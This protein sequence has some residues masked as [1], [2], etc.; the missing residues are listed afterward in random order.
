[1]PENAAS[2]R[3]AAIVVG[4]FDRPMKPAAVARLLDEDGDTCGQAEAGCSMLHAT[5]GD[6]LT[7]F[8][9]AASCSEG[10]EMVEP[11]GIEPLTFAMPLRRSPS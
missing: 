3:P 5:G 11:R 4:G 2:M 10:R 8:D 9:E 1:M 7:V 6:Q